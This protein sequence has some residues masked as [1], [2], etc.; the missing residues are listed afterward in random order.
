VKVSEKPTELLDLSDGEI[1][2]LK[3]LSSNVSQEDVHLLFDMCLK[4]A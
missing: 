4:I 2:S 3:Q 1:Q